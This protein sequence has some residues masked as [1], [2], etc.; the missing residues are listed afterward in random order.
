M[1]YKIKVTQ[2]RYQNDC[3][4]GL[5]RFFCFGGCHREIQSQFHLL[6]DSELDL[7]LLPDSVHNF[8]LDC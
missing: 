4:L 7:K 6:S 5:V 3:R 2:M 8:E 1:E